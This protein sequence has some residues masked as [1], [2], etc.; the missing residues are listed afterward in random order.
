MSIKANSHRDHEI[1]FDEST[2]E[3]KC[4]SLALADKSLAKLRSA[5]DR[6]TKERR[7]VAVPALYLYERWND[8]VPKISEVTV[9]LLREGDRKADIKEKGKRGQEQIEVRSLYAL[10]QRANLDAY[11]EAKKLAVAANRKANELE[12][13]L[14][15]LTAQA[16]REAVVL[17]AE[18][19]A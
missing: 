17:A 4:G 1:I 5:I 19:A 11:I 10:D 3:W 7:R 13:G 2:E 15:P 9:V 6:A 18:S 14:E 8:E 16:I 12:E